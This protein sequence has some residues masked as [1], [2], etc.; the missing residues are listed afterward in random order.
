MT[1]EDGTHS[2]FR[3]VVNNFNLHSVQNPK[4]KKSTSD[5]FAALNQTLKMS[6]LDL[7]K[8]NLHF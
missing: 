6:M 1:N 8:I 7:V 2:A 3:N 4:T 5:S